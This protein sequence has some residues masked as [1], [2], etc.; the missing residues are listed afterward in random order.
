MAEKHLHIITHD[1]PFPADFG[2]V[3][4]IFYKIKSLHQNGVKIHL[5][6]FENKRTRQIELEKYCEAVHYYERKTGLL[7]FSLKL[8]YIVSSR[9][10]NELL[11]NLKKDNYPI[12][13]E[14]VHCTYHFYNGKL[15]NRVVVLRLFNAEFEYYHHLALHEKNPFRKLYYSLESKLLKKYE[16]ELSKKIPILALSGKDVELYQDDFG[17]VNI[18]HLPVFLPYLDA[19]GQQGMGCYCLY[20]ANLEVNENEEAALWLAQHVFN[21]L[22]IPF[23]IAG[24]NPS[25]KLLFLTEQNPLACVV[26]NPSDK[27]L[28][29]LIAKA[30]INILP[31]F[32]NTGVKLKLLNAL[33]NGRHCIV[34]NAGV[35][36]SGLN[37]ACTMAEDEDDFKTSVKYLYEMPYTEEENIKRQQLLKL[38]DNQKNAEKLIDI[39]W[40]KHVV[41]C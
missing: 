30:Q 7:N 36:G 41:T 35:A 1:I 19:I 18:M 8:P 4:D 31:S 10:S 12:L 26:A 20:H 17:A 21:D 39:F 6:C 25:Q 16:Y 24:K 22:E 34:N 28:H 23:V 5:H 37:K 27:D 11:H 40:G 32:N 29:N 3:I 14:G 9:K 33:Y 15:N 13:F 2:G 38:Y